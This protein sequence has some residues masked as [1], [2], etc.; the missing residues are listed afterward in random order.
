MHKAWCIP[1]AMY[2]LADDLHSRDIAFKLSFM[3]IV[4]IYC[5]VYEV[6]SSGNPLS[7]T[8]AVKGRVDRFLGGEWR[9]LWRDCHEHP[10]LQV[11]A[12]PSRG[13]NEEEEAYRRAQKAKHAVLNGQISDGARALVQPGL[14]RWSQHE[15]VLLALWLA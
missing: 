7:P 15:G 3:M 1:L 2:S 13:Y 8:K 4:M 12:K 10:G 9:E 5:P 11:K 6:D 14:L